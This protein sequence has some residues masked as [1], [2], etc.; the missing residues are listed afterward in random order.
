MNIDGKVVYPGKSTEL[1][2]KAEPLSHYSYKKSQEKLS[3]GC[4]DSRASNGRRDSRG[5]CG[6]RDGNLSTS[7][8]K[9]GRDMERAVSHDNTGGREHLRHVRQAICVQELEE[10]EEMQFLLPAVL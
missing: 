1:W 3:S 5:Y 7:C 2:Q 9:E 4:R 8:D 10:V 6:S